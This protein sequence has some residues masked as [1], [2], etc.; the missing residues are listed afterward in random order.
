VAEDLILLDGSRQAEELSEL[1]LAL[2]S[3]YEFEPLLHLIQRSCR[4]VETREN[5]L[6]LF[7]IASVFI[8][9]KPEAGT[10]FFDAF[11]WLIHSLVGEN[12]KT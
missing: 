2:A 6:I 11:T 4:Q 12:R 8:N 10:A 1:S 3:A 7:Y 5:S 9:R